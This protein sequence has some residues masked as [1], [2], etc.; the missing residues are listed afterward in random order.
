[1]R[2][3]NKY[4]DNRLDEMLK[5][6]YSKEI[7]YTFRVKE[8][9]KE[10][11]TIMNT[12]SILKKAGVC[13]CAAA[14]ISAGIFSADIIGSFGSDKKSNSKNSFVMSVNA[15]EITDENKSA[16]I[17]LSSTGISYSEGDNGT[18]G[19]FFYPPIKCTG[20]NISTI[21][22]TV[23]HGTIEFVETSGQGEKK[24]P[25]DD[26]AESII[27]ED[28]P[29]ENISLGNTISYNDQN[30]KDISLSVSGGTESLS[31][32][33]QHLVRE[34]IEDLFGYTDDSYAESKS[35]GMREIKNLNKKVKEYMDILLDD[36]V[37]S[38]TVKFND[39]SKQTQQIKVGTKIMNAQDVYMSTNDELALADIQEELTPQEQKAKYD[40][41]DVF[42]TFTKI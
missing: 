10:T 9:I 20:E 6:Y 37:I 23:N 3:N 25:A 7:P 31:K 24:K 42:L 13:L 19:Y 29:Q 12:K 1:M 18:V 30:N 27:I 28:T 32:D 2:K 36:L 26:S 16:T 15:A 11:R 21:T 22:Y 4:S 38:C 14:V 5:N 35:E 17:D 39:G 8:N 40:F 34:H 33:K 41:E